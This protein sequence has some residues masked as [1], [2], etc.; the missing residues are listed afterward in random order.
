MDKTE[1]TD[2]DIKEVVVRLGETTSQLLSE[3]GVSDNFL[4]FPGGNI[5]IELFLK[6]FELSFAEK[7]LTCPQ[8]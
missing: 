5:V 4:D 1:V 8:Y 2:D 3:R 7:A 6:H